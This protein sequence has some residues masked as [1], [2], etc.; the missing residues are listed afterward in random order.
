MKI[1][2]G[3]GVYDIPSPSNQQIE[4]ALLKLTSDLNRKVN[5]VISTNGFKTQSNEF[6]LLTTALELLHE[7]N[8]I[9]AELETQKLNQ[10]NNAAAK[11][12]ADSD[13]IDHSKAKQLT[14][15]DAI[16]SDT[17][18]QDKMDNQFANQNETQNDEHL[19][20]IT[21]HQSD[22]NNTQYDLVIEHLED[23]LAR[24]KNALLQEPAESI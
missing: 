18:H 24:L 8:T 22:V 19:Q 4:S 21:T 11:G 20:Q 23:L 15:E 10:T 16:E 5:S 13:R 7:L 14:L 17:N 2:V 12:G 9:R 3:R 6:I 1:A